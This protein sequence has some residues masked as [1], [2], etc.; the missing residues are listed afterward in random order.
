M[1]DEKGLESGDRD[2]LA[3]WMHAPLTLSNGT[4]IPMADMTKEQLLDV[5]GQY[6]KRA[7]SQMT[8]AV[9]LTA[10]ANKMGAGTVEQEV[11]EVQLDEMWEALSGTPS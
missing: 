1:A 5:A 3:G 6:R 8:M 7:T 11:T 2:R 4:R 9:F 10:V